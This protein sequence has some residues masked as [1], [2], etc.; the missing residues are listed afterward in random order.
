MKSL[1]QKS[2]ITFFFLAI[3]TFSAQA[4]EL[5]YA[6]FPPASTFPSMQMDA[7]IDVIEKRTNNEVQVQTF[8]A[9]TLLDTKTMLR[10]IAQGQA[11]I[12]VTS[13]LYYPGSFPLFEVFGLP[14][15]FT[16]ATEASFVV[17]EIFKKYTPKE[18][19]RY[20]VLT[21][22]TSAPSQ[23]MS[24]KKIENLSDIKKVSLRA[25]GTISDALTAIGGNAVSIPMSETPE[26]L[27]KNVVDG[28]CSSFDTLYDM[29]FAEDCKFGL[30]V[31]MPVY[32][33][34][35]IM[36]KKSFDKLSDKAKEEIEN[37]SDEHALYTGKLVDASGKK[38]LDWAIKEHNFSH[39]NMSEKEQEEIRTKS[40]PLIEKW[41][42]NALDKGLDAEAILAD[43][44]KLRMLF[45]EKYSQN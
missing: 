24:T 25:S 16:S 30:S 3:C 41:K 38:A 1:L 4:K 33:F 17:W 45:K 44:E 34:V 35:V 13:L 23:I 32:P 7:W 31:N 19:A 15:G 5:R 26:A 10:G 8:P 12:G 40:A 22:F 9:S 43:I 20:K 36:N 29:N 28:V 27:Q 11:D 2:F 18:L 42:E 14:L 6:N 21:M 39:A 37:Y